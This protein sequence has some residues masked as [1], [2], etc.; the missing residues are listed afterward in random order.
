MVLFDQRAKYVRQRLVQRARLFKIDKPG[1]G[2][3]H[4]VAQLVRHHVDSDGKAVKYF[5]VAVA[6]YHLLT[7]PEGVLIF[8]AVMYGAGQNKPFIIERIALIFFPEEIMSNT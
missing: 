1:F 5:P 4:A 6:K 2:L 3:G 8:P 7:V